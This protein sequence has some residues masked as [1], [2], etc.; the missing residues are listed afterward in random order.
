[1]LQM[2]RVHDDVKQCI[3]SNGDVVKTIYEKYLMTFNKPK[4]RAFIISKDFQSKINL[5]IEKIQTIKESLKLHTKLHMK[6]ITTYI[7]ESQDKYFSEQEKGKIL[8]DIWNKDGEFYKMLKQL[9][10][11]T[12]NQGICQY[13]DDL[14]DD[15]RMLAEFAT[16]ISNII[17]RS[18]FSVEQVRK[19][20]QSEDL[21]G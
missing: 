9:D 15:D 12:S 13:F 21:K 10:I 17:G 14:L 19:F 8:K 6:Y 7:N 3:D 4:K 20:V 18:N 16:Y 2:N 11:E 5:I 1:M